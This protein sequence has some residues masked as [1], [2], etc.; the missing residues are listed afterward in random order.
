MPVVPNFLERLIL[1]RL[2]KGPSPIIEALGAGRLKA[3]E[4]SLNLGV[5]ENLNNQPLSSAALASRLGMDERG[6][7]ILLEMLEA[8]GY[9]KRKNGRFS[10][11]NITRKWLLKDA[12]ACVATWAVQLQRLQLEFWDLQLE[13]ALRKGKPSLPIYEWFDEAPM[14]WKI[15]Q[16][17][18]VQ[19]ARNFAAT[20]ASNV[21]LSPTA[22]RLLD[23][24]G[25]HGL[26]SVEF[27]RKN[28]GLS[29]TIFDVPG[30]LEVARETIAGEKMDDRIKVQPGD[31]RAD[32]MGHEYDVALLFNVPHGYT[33]EENLQL[34]EKIAS[35]LNPGGIIVISDP[36]EG[37]AG[38]AAKAL[39]RF[40]SLTF[41]ATL[42]GQIYSLRS[43]SQWLKE[44]GFGPPHRMRT[45]SAFVPPIL[46][47]SKLA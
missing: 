25:G 28:P 39:V 38:K 47:A 21:K 10:N 45:L 3:L 7:R 6:T 14:R 5:F 18:F 2:N 23:M 42:G 43:I 4:T 20:I 30:A 36:L 19:L 17:A 1:L 8:Y 35:L 29:A 37:L 41:F 32:D 22:R 46:V 24:G 27:C 16:T 15:A 9:V 34:L 31:F 40:F 12:P 44:A 13:E 33:P 26:Y 11:T